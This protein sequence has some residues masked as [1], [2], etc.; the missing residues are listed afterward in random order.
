M[1]LGAKV[2][3]WTSAN[4][5]LASIALVVVSVAVALLV[6]SQLTG[7]SR[8]TLQSSA[9]ALVFVALLGGL[10]KLLLDDSQRNRDRRTEQARFVS[11][12]LSDLK[13]VYDQVERSRIVI[14]AHRSARTYGEE[15]RG[16]IDAR[17][18]LQNVARA[19]DTGTTGIADD[20]RSTITESVAAMEAYLG[21]LTDEFRTKY[22]EIS[23]AQ[24]V[25]Q[26]RVAN[27]LSSL[28]K[29]EGSADGPTGLPPNTPWRKIEELS[30]LK[31]MISGEGYSSQFVTPLD[32]ASRALREELRS[33]L[34][35]SSPAAA[36]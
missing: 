28:A 15:M 21:R 8:E 1:R 20:R 13:A 22:K 17:V 31:D 32:D 34:H 24:S 5:I 3:G 36:V 4:P 7:K 2:A 10:V 16:L 18:Q 27:E 11:A 19:L 25:Y 35:L 30:E 14:E 9:I 23:D 33:V 12:M 6:A 29:D 26:A